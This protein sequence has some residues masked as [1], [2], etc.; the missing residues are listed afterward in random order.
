M[1][2]DQYTTPRI[3][4]ALQCLSGAKWFSVLALRSGY[5]QIPMHPEDR[6]KTMFICTL[7][8]YEFNRLPQGLSG[9]PVTFQRLMERTVE[10]MKLIEVLVY[11]DDIIVFGETL[12]Q[13]EEHLK[14]VLTSFHEEGLKLSLEKCQ[15]YQPSV[16]Y[17]GYVVLAD[18]V[19]MD[20]AK[21]EAVVSWPRPQNVAEL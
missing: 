15:F 5:H 16:T 6:E 14:K 21:L 12:E 11:L 10:D 9:A 17:L 19:A 7:G 2:P 20:P 13:H 8:F 18:G 3:E 1:I 4:D